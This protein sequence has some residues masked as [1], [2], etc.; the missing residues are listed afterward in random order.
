MIAAKTAAAM[1]VGL[2][3]TLSVASFAQNGHDQPATANPT[4]NATAL[5]LSELATVDWIEKSDVAAL[6]EGVIEKMELRL[7]DPALVSKPIGYLHREAAELTV[8]KNKILAESVG[9]IEK[10]KAAVEVAASRVA[11]NKRLNDRKPGMVSAEDV[12]KDEGELKV[13][14]AQ[15]KEAMENQAAAQAELAL[16][17]EILKEH[18]IV[19]PFDGV[20]IKRYKNPGESVR[21]N[22]AVV[23]IGKLSRLAANAYVPLKHA[24][25]VKE[26]Q[27]A[28]IRPKVD[29][30]D[31]GNEEIE[32]L[33]FRGKITF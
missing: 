4:A 18:T 24:F 11:R 33:S 1:A 32:S 22:E 31:G 25:K 30:I 14:D 9:A 20:V 12:A 19:A 28:E 13:A 17:R 2:L 23:Q 27:I 5:V 29:S 16:A 7:G 6:R 8:A 21:A 3:T 15:T 10:G 26:G